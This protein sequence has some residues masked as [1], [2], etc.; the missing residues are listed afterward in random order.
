MMFTRFLNCLTAAGID[1][2]TDKT[3]P[4]EMNLFIS[5]DDRNKRAFCDALHEGCFFLVFGNEKSALYGT[6]S[7]YYLTIY[8]M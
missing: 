4:K 7:G 6:V 8:T 5:K 1:Y 3:A 2:M